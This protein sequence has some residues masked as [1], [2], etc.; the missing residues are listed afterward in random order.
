MRIIW[1]LIRLCRDCGSDSNYQAEQLVVVWG[2][3]QRVYGVYKDIQGHSGVC[4][5][6]GL[7][8]YVN[9]SHGEACGQENRQCNG[10][11]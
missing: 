2:P 10:D 1:G 5:L 6:Y 9:T 11:P 3:F 7:G 4:R 8:A